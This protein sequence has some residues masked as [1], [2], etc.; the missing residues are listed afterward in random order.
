MK[1]TYTNYEVRKNSQYRHSRISVKDLRKASSNPPWIAVVK[2]TTLSVRNAQGMLQKKK[3]TPT[4][5]KRTT[6][7][8]G[9]PDNLDYTRC[10]CRLAEGLQEG[11]QGSRADAKKD[12]DVDNKKFIVSLH[13]KVVKCR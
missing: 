9:I 2:I 4:N 12:E 5:I 7:G 11:L 8:E 10:I 3:L 1:Q 13:H 6:S